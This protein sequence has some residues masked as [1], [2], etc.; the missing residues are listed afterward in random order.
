MAGDAVS[1]VVAVSFAGLGWSCEG[2]VWRVAEF[3]NDVLLV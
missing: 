2:W 1:E 3:K